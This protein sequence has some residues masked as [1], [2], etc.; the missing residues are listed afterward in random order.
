MN[1]QTNVAANVV[2]KAVYDKVE[3]QIHTIE[4]QL[5]TLNAKA[6]SAKADAELNAIANLATAKRTLDQKVA[7]LKK[8]GGARFQVVKGEVEARIAEFEKSVKAIESRFRA[9]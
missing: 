2:E 6:E 8:A 7:E 5:A 9:G 4:A 3:S 1:T